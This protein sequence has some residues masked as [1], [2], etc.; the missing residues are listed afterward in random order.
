MSLM[1]DDDIDRWWRERELETLGVTGGEPQLLP[2]I[3][4]G[5]LFNRHAKK[6][7]HCHYHHCK[8]CNDGD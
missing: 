8:G 5:G 2:C 7:P 4:C 3:K 6:C 1:S